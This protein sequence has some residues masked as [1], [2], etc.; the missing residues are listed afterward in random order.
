MTDDRIEQS[1]QTSAQAGA[2]GERTAERPGGSADVTPV[3][4]SVAASSA[5]RPKR[6]LPP[7]DPKLTPLAGVG[8]ET[9]SPVGPEEDVGPEKTLPLPDPKSIRPLSNPRTSFPKPSPTSMPPNRWSPSGTIHPQPRTRR[10]RTHTADSS[11]RHD[12]GG[13]PPRRLRTRHPPKSPPRSRRARWRWCRRSPSSSASTSSAPGSPPTRNHRRSSRRWPRPR[14]RPNRRPRAPSPRHSIPWPR[15]PRSTVPRP[16]QQRPVP[17]S[18]RHPTQP[19]L[20]PRRAFLDGA[21]GRPSGSRAGIRPSWRWYRTAAS[22]G[23]RARTGSARASRLPWTTRPL[24]T[25]G[26]A[27]ATSR[28]RTAGGTDHEGRRTHGRAGRP[29]SVGTDRR[30]RHRVCPDRLRRAGD[31]QL[32]GRGHRGRARPFRRQVRRLRDRDRPVGDAAGKWYR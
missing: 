12:P 26:C 10:R 30:R 31:R 9:R 22:R 23:L 6:T 17:R 28:N 1:A 16:S 13:T 5:V 3:V 21:R 11:Q 2:N 19:T 24:G 18:S 27:E 15:S 4:G 25:S 20:G 14:H 7:S 8:S 29:A 32:A